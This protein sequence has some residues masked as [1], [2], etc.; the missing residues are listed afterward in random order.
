MPEN[1]QDKS[2]KETGGDDGEERGIHCSSA[3]HA[4][5]LL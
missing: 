4:L 5:T 3:G 2:E 1:R